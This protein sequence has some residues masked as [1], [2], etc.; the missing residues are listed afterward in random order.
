MPLPRIM[1]GITDIKGVFDGSLWET[2]EGRVV[3]KS[4]T[5]YRPKKHTHREKPRVCACAAWQRADKIWQEMPETEKSEWNAAVKR[6]GM[7]GYALWMMEAVTMF[8]LGLPAP[9]SPSPSGGYAVSK[10]RP[11][12]RHMPPQA[13]SEQ[14][15]CYRCREAA[16][17][18]AQLEWGLLIPTIRQAWE[19]EAQRW[20]IPGIG[21][22]AW[23]SVYYWTSGRAC[24]RTP[25][26]L[27]EYEYPWGETLPDI[28]ATT[29]IVPPT[30]CI[31]LY[32]CLRGRVYWWEQHY[33]I[34]ADCRPVVEG[35]AP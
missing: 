5:P 8:A 21:L 17:E 26:Q 14:R 4:K 6:P 35:C 7:C 12:T 11:G 25:D 28:T 31:N 29:A 33:S 30:A 19:Q 1:Y 2:R 13:C 18:K 32:L 10:I 20:S 16:R 24:A 34:P 9:D 15:A 3:L 23:Q 27:G 22:W